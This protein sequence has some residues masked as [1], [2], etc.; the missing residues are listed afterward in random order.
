MKMVGVSFLL[1][2]ESVVRWWE[3]SE[4]DDFIRL[5]TK[6]MFAQKYSLLDKNY[7]LR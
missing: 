1:N 5:T 6:T 7:Q 3:S 4:E 2:C